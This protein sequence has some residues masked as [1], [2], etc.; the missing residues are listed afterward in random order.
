MIFTFRDQLA[1]SASPGEML[2]RAVAALERRGFSQVRTPEPELEPEPGPGP[3][4]AGARGAAGGAGERSAA[5]SVRALLRRGSLW[6]NFFRNRMD[7][8]RQTLEVRLTREPG[9]DALELVLL[10]TV[11][12]IGQYMTETNRGYF[13]AESTALVHELSG[14]TDGEALLAAHRKQSWRETVVTLLLA[15]LGGLALGRLLWAVLG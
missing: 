7:G 11:S 9:Q 5:A 4:P 12:T 2:Q 10:Y 14:R 13:R 3:G 6:G 15:A 1:A 8:L